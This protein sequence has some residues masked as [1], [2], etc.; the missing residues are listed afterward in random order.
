MKKTFIIANWKSN[1]TESE[2]KNW[3]QAIN[4]SQLA[5]DEGKKI[6]VCPPFTLLPKVK[7][8]FVNYQSSIAVGAQDISP[9]GE[10]AYTGEVNGREIKEFADY[11]IVGH[12]ERRINFSESD[13]LVNKKIEQAYLQGIIPI[14]CVSSLDQVKN[15]KV[16]NS[17]T[18]IAYEPLFAIGSGTADTPENADKMASDVK[19]ILGEIPILYGGS[20]TSGNVSS[21]SKMPNIDGVLI[22]KASLEPSEF[23]KL[24]KN[25]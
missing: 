21:F 7:E 20:V 23:I 10:G 17:K 18:L 13:E 3:L 2:A 4:N 19:N 25:A 9:F 16:D 11:V 22:G 24:S 6:I 15:L 14:V 12:S 5:V 8:F 1:E